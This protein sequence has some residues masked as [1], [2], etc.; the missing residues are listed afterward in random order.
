MKQNQREIMWY[1]KRAGRDILP[2]KD[3]ETGFTQ[4]LDGLRNG[5]VPETSPAG[6][7]KIPDLREILIS[8]GKK[9]IKDEFA[10]DQ[11][12]IKLQGVKSELDRIINTYLESVL[13]FASLSGITYHD[14]DPCSFFSRNLDRM[15]GENDESGILHELWTTGIGLCNY[16]TRL[17]EYLKVEIRKVM[18]NT[19]SLVG[20]D[21]TLD[22]LSRSGGLKNLV[23]YP[24]STIQVL[25]AEK[26]FFKHMTMGTPPPKHG[27]IFRHPDV[28]PLKPSKRGKASRAIANKIAITSK[29]DFLGT[30][31]DVDTIRK[32]LDK[33][34]K[35]IKSGQ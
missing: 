20:E 30:K 26:A 4:I 22:I 17:S 3:L 2:F 12:V 24:S 11:V 7:T 33:R 19:S 28:S 13:P 8:Y 1:G 34:L 9:R 23:K 27:V 35:E 21:L 14:D 6:S 5:V 16:R 29:A 25:G 15:Q 10:G 32:Q 31:M 18:Q